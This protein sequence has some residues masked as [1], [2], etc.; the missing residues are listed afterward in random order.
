[1]I[2]KKISLILIVLVFVSLFSNI[3]MANENQLEIDNV[4]SFDSTENN[5]F[6]ISVL[7][8]QGNPIQNGQGSVYSFFEEKMVGN[9]ELDDNGEAVFKY[10]PPKSMI[11]NKLEEKEIIDVQYLVTITNGEELAV[12][13]FTQTYYAP[14]V[15][16]GTFRKDKSASIMT[17]DKRAFNVM[18]EKPENIE[19]L[20]VEEAEVSL[21]DISQSGEVGILYT[22]VL[23]SIS[24]G[25]RE[26]LFIS[27]NAATGT[28]ITGG[29]SQGSIT[30]L[31]GTG[32]LSTTFT[33]SQGI[34]VSQPTPVATFGL[35][36]DF[37]TYYEYVEEKY[38]LYGGG[39][40]Y[41][42]H[43]IRPAQWYGG[44]NYRTVYE[45]RN[46]ASPNDV[47]WTNTYP[48]GSTVQVSQGD[49]YSIGVGVRL[50]GPISNTT[51]TVSLNHTVNSNT[52][53]TRKHGNLG[54][55]VTYYE[56]GSGLPIID[57]FITRH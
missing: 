3:G 6:K 42:L 4:I 56:Y 21:K 7:D 23:E 53:I 38:R 54:E 51:Y 1:M 39:Y 44:I 41:I 2:K 27:G 15:I 26:T 55:N 12:E 37:Y 52:S 48:S 43:R 30:T 45:S 20:I 8:S 11:Q 29:I 24:L 28:S 31:S 57:R 49:S 14:H 19:G 17:D 16:D 34:S 40:S 36:R 13:G 50:T 9:F 47:N 22:E 46:Q 25:S 5:L 32:V 35:R 10:Q 18:T 33:A